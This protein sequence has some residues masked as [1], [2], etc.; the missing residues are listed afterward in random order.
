MILYGQD[1][2]TNTDQ[3]INGHSLLREGL[4]GKHALVREISTRGIIQA[5]GYSPRQ[6]DQSP[7][8]PRLAGE[9]ER[10]RGE[11]DGP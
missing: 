6:W 7:L 5:E 11:T 10:E 8:A 9:R 4:I 3:E 1:G 2:E